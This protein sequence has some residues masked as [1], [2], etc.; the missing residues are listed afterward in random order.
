MS[1]KK[2]DYTLR[3][4]AIL[5]LIATFIVVL[6]SIISKIFLD[7][8]ECGHVLSRLEAQGLIKIH[9]KA[10]SGRF[11]FVSITSKGAVAAGLPKERG[12]L[13]GKIIDD[14][15][16]LAFACF[17]DSPHRRYLLPNAEA[18]RLL[19]STDCIPSNVDIIAADEPNAFGLYR[20]YRPNNAKA[21]AAGLDS[22]YESFQ[23][24]AAI[25]EALSMGVFGIA[26]LARDKK[27]SLQL[28]S[29][30]SQNRNPLAKN[31]L[32]L[33]ALAPG[34]D[35]LAACLKIKKSAA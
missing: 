33:V 15:L 21:A 22:L 24:D 26:L 12:Q 32:H 14:Q 29:V 5:R 6:K 20:V 18:N 17:C 27:L 35:S 34:V 2:M 9:S 3:D 10:A 28:K 7:G 8:K 23:Q 1:T 16:G 13:T 30:V 31:C 19:N 4:R 25:K 11:T